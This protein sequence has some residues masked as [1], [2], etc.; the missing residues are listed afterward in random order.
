M[1]SDAVITLGPLAFDD[2]IPGWKTAWVKDP[3]GN[4]IE[5]T[6]GYVD[7]ED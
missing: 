7:Q 4:I 6:Q 2:F 5:I 1:G 3:E